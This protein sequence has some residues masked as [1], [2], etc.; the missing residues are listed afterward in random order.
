MQLD[1]KPLDPIGVEALGLDLRTPIDDAT[2]AALR[3]TVLDEGL[4][5]FRDQPIEPEVQV[6]LGR[7]F[8]RL[9][10][11]LLDSEEAD[12]DEASAEGGHVVIG[13]VGEDG[14]VLPDDH[15]M[16][17][18]ISINEGW[19]TDSSFREVPASFSI[20]ACVVAPEEGGDTFFASLERA[21]Q[22][23]SPE[24]Q[25]RLYDL[26]GVHDYHAAYR[27]RGSEEGSV[28]GY[29]G[30]PLRHPLARRH[31][32]TG[33][34]VLYVSEHVSHVAGLPEDESRALLERLL[35]VCTDPARV[36]RHHWHP[37]DIAIWDNRSMLHR[38]Q[39][40]DA[41]HARVMHHVRIG[42][43]EV[44]IRATSA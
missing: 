40:F 3:A 22:A 30:P 8:G 27:R 18:L 12:E 26:D 41:R 15:P 37:G 16:M 21:W 10:V 9:E 42:G 24:E 2:L 35:A 25:A 11:L 23:L 34:T 4:V 39:G 1:T 19:H 29:H 5:L 20:F 13:N 17:K 6:A 33:R 7:R 36:Y 28:V 14:R 44:P 38:A 43:T 32:E 31:P